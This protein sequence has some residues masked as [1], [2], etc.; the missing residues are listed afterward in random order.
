MTI[1]VPYNIQISDRIVDEWGGVKCPTDFVNLLESI[2]RLPFF[3][4][5][6]VSTVG[7]TNGI[8]AYG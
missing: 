4:S 2:G 3:S 7:S 8:S 1:L 6:T 5:I